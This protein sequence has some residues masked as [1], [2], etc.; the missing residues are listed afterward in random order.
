MQSFLQIVEKDVLNHFGLKYLTLNGS[1][2]SKERVEV[3][4]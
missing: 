4:E 1:M 2:S 3:V